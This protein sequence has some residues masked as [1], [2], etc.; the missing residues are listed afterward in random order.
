MK[1]WILKAS[2]VLIFSLS[3]SLS[4]AY[5]SIFDW[6]K[7][8]GLYELDSSGKENP[9]S[10]PKKIEFRIGIKFFGPGPHRT[11]SRD[12]ENSVW[13]EDLNW[14]AGWLSYMAINQGERTYRAVLP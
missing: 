7:Y 4:F 5:P 10:C 6:Q 13:I 3:A 9:D 2:A 11:P 14:H 8:T 1:S 12:E